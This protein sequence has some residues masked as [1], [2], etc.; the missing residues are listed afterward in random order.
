MNPLDISHHDLSA[1]IQDN[2]GTEEV[3]REKKGGWYRT[4]IT[5]V[6]TNIQKA[7]Q[8]FN[9]LR[10]GLPSPLKRRNF[11]IH[12]FSN[13]GIS[14]APQARFSKTTHVQGVSKPIP[15]KAS[16]DRNHVDAHAKPNANNSN[17]GLKRAAM[18][19]RL[20]PIQLTHTGREIVKIESPDSLRE[21]IE[22]PFDE[23]GDIFKEES[24]N[25]FGELFHSIASLVLSEEEPKLQTYCSSPLSK[26]RCLTFKSVQLIVTESSNEILEKRKENRNNIS[27]EAI[28]EIK[29]SISFKLANYFEEFENEVPLSMKFEYKIRKILEKCS[30]LF[31]RQSQEFISQ[32]L[33]DFDTS[34]SRFREYYN[35][36][37]GEVEVLHPHNPFSR[38]RNK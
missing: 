33:E 30:F 15:L 16:N 4:A 26:M 14:D 25:S 8:K 24:E 29:D 34:I 28:E 27:D 35:S 31:A 7:T 5:C 6:L 36:P 21:Y 12:N 38:H 18:K 17:K 1:F 9:Q 10:A 2:R 23:I 13:V 19:Q 11:K 22:T 3:G 20:K 32:I 37:S